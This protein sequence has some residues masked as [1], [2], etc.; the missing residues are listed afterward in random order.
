MRKRRHHYIPKFYLRP[1][2]ENERVFCMRGRIIKP[3]GLSHVGVK[4][5]FYAVR[6]LTMDDIQFL[7]KT[8]IAQ[9]P[10][11]TRAIHENTLY[12]F[13]LVAF[14]NRMLQE[15][16]SL[17][18][19]A[20]REILDAVSNLDENYHESIEHYLQEAIN[21]MLSGTID[22]FSDV[23]KAGFF[24]MSLGLFALRTKRTRERMKATIRPPF[25]GFDVDRIYGPMIHMLAVNLGGNLLVDRFR[26]RI[27]LLHNYTTTAFITG[28]QPVINIHESMDEHGIPREVEWYFPLSPQTAMLY[29]LADNRCP[30]LHKKIAAADA[31]FY[32]RRIVAEHHDQ[33]YG[34]SEKS[35]SPY[36]TD[37]S[38][39]E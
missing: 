10:E 30:S 15:N 16:P 14:A 39:T 29:V 24:L 22:F 32:N 21:N 1:W 35:L 8:I 25:E 31:D 17:E 4:E 38:I 37:I 2:S 34:I 28:D 6:D 18:N 20:K 12:A 11:G 9:S 33:L 19:Q 36:L 13:R 3:I 27:V 26:Y 5:D 7:E 23:S